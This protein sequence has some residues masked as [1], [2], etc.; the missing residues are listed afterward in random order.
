MDDNAKKAREADAKRL[1]DEIDELT[2]K[3]GEAAP[4][5]SPRDFIHQKM[6]EEQATKRPRRKKKK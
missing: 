5:R 6:A 2:R 4:P 1:E 3:G